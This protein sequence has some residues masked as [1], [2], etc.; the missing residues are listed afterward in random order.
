MSAGDVNV[1]DA[2]PARPQ[3]AAAE[4]VLVDQVGAVR[5]VT[6]NRPA[7][8]NALTGPM[9]QMLARALDDAEADEGTSV[10]VLRGAG[11]SFSAGWDLT[12]AGTGSHDVETDR[13]RLHDSAAHIGR[14]WACSLPVVAQVH[15]HCLAGGADLA[16]HCDLLVM[17]DDA[18]IGYPPVRSLGVPTSHLWAY[19]AGGQ[20]ARLLLYT[21]DTITGAEAAARGL[22]L[23]A[24]PAADL[25]AT[26]AG[27]ASRIALSSRDVLAAN[28]RVLQHADDLMGR[29]AL[30]RFAQSEDLLAHL[31]PA[32]EAFRDRVRTG[33]TTTAF[34]ERDARFGAGEEEVQ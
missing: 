17:A 18:R 7:K 13:R 19:R 2:P 8:H 6:L 4:P 29:E 16:L 20:L 9:M 24:V 30:R 11:P 15:G 28:K 22:A 26:V 31:S 5:T 25:P 10:V 23:L 33:G 14:V 3:G 27:I 32:A 1:G 34:R 21:G 12:G